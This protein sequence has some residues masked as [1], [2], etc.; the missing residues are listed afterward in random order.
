MM[1]LSSLSQLNKEVNALGPVASRISQENHTG[2]HL[3]EEATKACLPTFILLSSFKDT[4]PEEPT[5]RKAW[6]QA[7]ELLEA[8]VESVSQTVHI[9]T[10]REGS[11]SETLTQT[12]LCI[13]QLRQQISFPQN[14]HSSP[15]STGSP[16]SSNNQPSSDGSPD[17]SGTK[18]RD[19]STTLLPPSASYCDS[20]EA[21]SL[22][23]PLP[24]ETVT[25]CLQRR[26]KN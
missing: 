6:S 22:F 4:Q 5:E 7:L 18:T 10:F 2:I 13:A 16:K 3:R 23:Q 12:D 17:S 21:R 25:D 20:S 14:N 8:I 24:E 1:E 9:K 19:S 26:V 11:A 15:T